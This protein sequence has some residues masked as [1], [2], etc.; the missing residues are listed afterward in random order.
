MTYLLMSLPFVGVALV[1]FVLGAVHAR[2]HGSS[3]IYLS[4]WAAT[5]ASLIILTVVFDNVMMAAGFFDYGVEHISGV[6][7]G[8]IPI[9]DLMYPIAGALLL[10]G[11]WQM[12][13][14]RRVGGAGESGA[15]EV[16]RDA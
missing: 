5:T 8:L 3:A 1:M 12:L 2:R 11:A 13:S 4:A 10:S 9:E 14:G 6:R 16:V 15:G 7:L